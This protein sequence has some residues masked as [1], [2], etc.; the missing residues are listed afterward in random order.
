MASQGGNGGKSTSPK[1]PTQGTGS[2]SSGFTVGAPIAPGESKDSDL[3]EMVMNLA[4][5]FAAMQNQMAANAV[6]S[7]PPP[8]ATAAAVAGTADS[9]RPGSLSAIRAALG[10]AA[11]P[12]TPAWDRP[13]SLSSLATSQ[14]KVAA[15]GGDAAAGGPAPTSGGAPPVSD[16]K[17]SGDVLSNVTTTGEVDTDASDT[18]ALVDEKCAAAQIEYMM[19]DW[20]KYITWHRNIKWTNGQ[21]RREAANLAQALDAFLF[22]DGIDC[23]D[24]IGIEI[25]TRRWAG[26]VLME[27]GQS[28]DVADA[29]EYKDKRGVVPRAILQ[30]AM[31]EAA[32]AK[33]WKAQSGGTKKDF[34]KPKYGGG[35]GN[36][37]KGKPND[38]KRAGGTSTTGSAAAGST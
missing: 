1:R 26:L 29:L 10:Y 20:G 12:T 36:K 6:R 16:G 17:G 2:G 30:A 31:K 21:R 11:P 33:K 19:S 24:S 18:K 8:T 23:T 27:D 28:P 32:L 15:P 9:G 34:T 22:V 13:S 38:G 4:K 25:M 35:G 14:P 37:K 7:L 3:R 5:S